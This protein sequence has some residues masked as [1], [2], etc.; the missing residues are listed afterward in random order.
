MKSQCVAAFG[1]PCPRSRL[2]DERHLLT[3]KARLIANDGTSA[4]LALQAMTHG[5]A[6]WLALNR[7]VKLTAAAGGASGHG[8]DPWLSMT[9]VMRPSSFARWYRVAN[10]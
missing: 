10:I 6:R 7:K 8:S 1:F 3:A 9:S 5:N 4:A 2:T